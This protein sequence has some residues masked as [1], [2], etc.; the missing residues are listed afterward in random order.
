MFLHSRAGAV[1]YLVQ[2][3]SYIRFVKFMRSNNTQRSDLGDIALVWG[4]G[5]SYSVVYYV[6]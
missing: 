6:R 4:Y 1:T 5:Y 3:G 2:C